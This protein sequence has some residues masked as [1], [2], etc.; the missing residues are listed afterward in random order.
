MVAFPRHPICPTV[1][2]WFLV[3]F[4]AA[5]RPLVIPLAGIA[6]VLVGLNSAAEAGSPA[7]NLLLTMGAFLGGSFAVATIAALTMEPSQEWQRIGVRVI[8]SW[9]RGGVHPSVSRS[10]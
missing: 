9:D 3:A 4:D 8:G 5:A 6:G 1:G 10:N 2:H 7:S